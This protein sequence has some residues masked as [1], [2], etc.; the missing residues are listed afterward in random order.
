MDRQKQ[1]VGITNC[2]CDL[3]LKAMTSNFFV[4]PSVESDDMNTENM[5]RA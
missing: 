5:N 3:E 1:I 2:I 4:S